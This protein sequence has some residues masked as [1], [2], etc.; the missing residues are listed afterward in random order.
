VGQCCSDRGGGGGPLVLTA[1]EVSDVELDHAIEVTGGTANPETG[2]ATVSGTLTCNERSVA[3]REGTLRQIREG[4][5]VARGY[6]S[7]FA[8]CTPGT[9][10]EWSI[11]V[12][13]DTGIAFGPGSAVMKS[14][15]EGAF[16][17]WRDGIYTE[18]VPDA[19]I[20]LE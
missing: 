6:F 3:Y 16:D 1:D 10:A 18:D 19:T 7:L 20:T 9:P 14:W 17:G 11:E 13:T 8:V 15:Y 12:D 5:F 4:L 2:M